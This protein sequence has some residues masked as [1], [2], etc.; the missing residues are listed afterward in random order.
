FD[1]GVDVFRVFTEDHHIGFLGLFN[2]RRHALE[3]LDGAQADIQVQLL[4]Q[5]NVQRTDAAAN[6]GGQWALDGDHVVLDSFQGFVGQPDIRT[7]Y[8]RR[9]F[10]SEDFHPV[11][12][13]LAVVSLGDSGVNDFQH[14]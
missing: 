7:I 1:A 10:A 12:F 11:D 2:W 4:A 6:R 9:L 8:F 5:R 13:A 3:V 14:D